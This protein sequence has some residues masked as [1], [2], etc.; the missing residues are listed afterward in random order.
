MSDGGDRTKPYTQHVYRPM[1]RP[2]VIRLVEG[3]AHEGPSCHLYLSHPFT[4]D[5]DL[6][7]KLVEGSPARPNYP[8]EEDDPSP[9]VELVEEVGEYVL[10]GWLTSERNRERD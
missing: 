6:A 9:L 4:S 5:T 10:C 1:D 8:I 7:A 2:P 3:F